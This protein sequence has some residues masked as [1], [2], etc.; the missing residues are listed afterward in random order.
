MKSWA[1]LTE[2]EVMVLPSVQESCIQG[3]VNREEWPRWTQKLG[4][5]GDG[6]STWD[7]AIWPPFGG[8]VGISRTWA[9]Q[10]GVW[11]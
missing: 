6:G 3:T 5:L 10:C 1:A 8:L 11:S 7:T 9:H 2:E 4:S